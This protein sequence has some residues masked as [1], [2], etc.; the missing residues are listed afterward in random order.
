MF[1]FLEGSLLTKIKV[2]FGAGFNN[3]KSFI[4]LLSMSMD[5]LKLI[6]SLGSSHCTAVWPHPCCEFSKLFPKHS[7][8]MRPLLGVCCFLRKARC[9]VPPNS[10]FATFSMP[11]FELLA[12]KCPMHFWQKKKRGVVLVLHYFLNQLKV[13]TIL[14]PPS[15]N[16]GSTSASMKRQDMGLT[17]DRSIEGGIADS[18]IQLLCWWVQLRS[19]L[20]PDSLLELTAVTNGLVWVWVQQV[21]CLLLAIPG[22]RLCV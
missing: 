11:S 4:F 13:H 7:G 21:T 20:L 1:F 9:L 12:P 10:V 15:G 18:G 5:L 3:V 16:C 14:H 6:R 19:V 17:V 8:V 22:G 2:N